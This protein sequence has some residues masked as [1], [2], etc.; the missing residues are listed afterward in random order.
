MFHVKHF[1]IIVMVNMN[2]KRLINHSSYKDVNKF[3]IYI[4]FSN[5]RK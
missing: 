1:I 4:T 2:L 5:G 3:M